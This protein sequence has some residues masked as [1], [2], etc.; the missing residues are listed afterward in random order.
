MFSKRVLTL[1][2]KDYNP[3][4]LFTWTTFNPEL[5]DQIFTVAFNKCFIL[6]HSEHGV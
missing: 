2:Q 3:C 1:G 5:S 6:L 4:F